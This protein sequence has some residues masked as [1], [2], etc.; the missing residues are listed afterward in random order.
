MRIRKIRDIRY[1][2][3]PFH[4]IGSL[5]ANIYKERLVLKLREQ[6]FSLSNDFDHLYISFTTNIKEGTFKRNDEEIDPY[7]KWYR[8]CFFGI[9]EKD[10]EKLEQKSANWFLEKVEIILVES[11]AKNEQE[12]NLIKTIIKEIKK[13]KENYQ[14][15]F[16]EKRG[17]YHIARIYLRVDEKANYL[18]RLEVK[19]KDEKLVLLNID[20][21]I[22]T[23]FSEFGRIQLSKE[24]VTIHPRE[25]S[26]AEYKN[27]KP[28][29]FDI[30]N[31]DSN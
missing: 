4:S 9:N 2:K 27:L 21:P 8:Y 15:I 6:N 7:H 11:F 31:P 23:D 17:R 19:T 10:Y 18:P 14:V 1:F 25:S 5:E 13:Q 12:K 3:E 28:M 22:T 29:V 16:K 30:K 24:T 26:Y 20:L